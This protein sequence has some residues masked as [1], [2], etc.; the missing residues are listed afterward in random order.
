MNKFLLF[1]FFILLAIDSKGQNHKLFSLKN[2]E[3]GVSFS[4]DYSGWLLH[5]PYSDS[6]EFI[7]MNEKYSFNKNYFGFTGGINFTQKIN[8]SLSVE[9]GIL[10]S[11]KGEI[12]TLEERNI[13]PR[14]GY[15][16]GEGYGFPY[17]AETTYKYH[18]LNVP[19]KLNYYFLK[20]KFSAFISG[21]LSGDVFLNQINSMKLVNEDGSSENKDEEEKT[22][23]RISLTSLIGFGIHYKITDMLSF[24]FEPI[25]RYTIN[26]LGDKKVNPYSIGTNIGIFYQ[27]KN[28]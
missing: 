21:G 4:P 1:L 8:N 25:L 26:K 17:I 27:I 24:R 3:I 7:G 22:L 28:K 11:K 19:L 16:Y 2:T 9:S 20:R 14:Y 15:I 18:Y 13:H 6:S 23:T 10:Y 5:Q 12:V